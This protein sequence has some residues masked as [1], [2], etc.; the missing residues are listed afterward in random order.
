MFFVYNGRVYS[1]NYCDKSKHYPQLSITFGDTGVSMRRTGQGLDKM[2]KEFDI[3]TLHE[4]QAR[5]A[6][7]AYVPEE[8]ADA[9]DT[10]ATAATP[11]R[12]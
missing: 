12:T 4:I 7:A 3:L 5:Y 9:E 8:V 2:P 1:A 11:K 10:K 6:K